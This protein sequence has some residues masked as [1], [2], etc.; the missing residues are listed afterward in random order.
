M[1]NA[2]EAMRPTSLGKLGEAVGEVAQCGANRY[3][4]HTECGYGYACGCTEAVQQEHEPSD[5]YGWDCE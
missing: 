5:R 4:K 3:G 2:G 1:V